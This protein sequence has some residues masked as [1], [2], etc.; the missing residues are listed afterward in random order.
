[1]LTKVPDARIEG[2]LVEP[3][4]PKGIE[5]IVGMKHDPSFGPML[6]FGLGGIYVELFTDISFR[7]AP[8]SAEETREMILETRAGKLLSGFRGEKPVKLDGLIECIQRLGQLALDFPEIQEVEIN[9]LL[10]L[11]EGHQVMALDCRLIRGEN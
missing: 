2:V 7:I 11:P 4:I 5:V 8:V 1:M 10:V 9:P 3:M 6:M